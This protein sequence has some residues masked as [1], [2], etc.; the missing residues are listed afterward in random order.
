MRF[1][2]AMLCILFAFLLLQF[3]AS[4]GSVYASV[5]HVLRS[6]KI[7]AIFPLS[8]FLWFKY[9]STLSKIEL[10]IFLHGIL[11]I[12]IPLSLFYIMSAN[13]LA[14]YRA[15]DTSHVFF[16][17][18]T[19]YGTAVRDL[20]TI[21]AFLFVSLSYALALFAL[22]FK[23]HYALI[24]FLLIIA[25]LSTATRGIA[26]A[27]ILSLAVTMLHIIC[28]HNTSN[29]LTQI[30][31]IC[32]IV[33]S[34]MLL[35]ARLPILHHLQSRIEDV[36][37]HGT[38]TS[39]FQHRSESIN[40]V[41]SLISN[42]TYTFLFGNGYITSSY[43]SANIY[44]YFADSMYSRLLYMFGTLGLLLY[45]VVLSFPIY[46]AIRYLF[47]LTSVPLLTSTL[48]SV[49]FLSMAY[50]G[51]NGVNSDAPIYALPYGLFLAG[52]FLSNLKLSN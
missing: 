31:Y 10:H 9:F 45:I 17:T 25:A 51:S 14:L 27:L 11:Y 12:T 38:S 26:V 36:S 16:Q 50:I 42:D 41:M 19:M 15:P 4:T 18:S 37:E 39:N 40:Y 2:I 7:Y 47:R 6:S 33:L 5:L 8:I 44:L 34:F 30:F 20:S 43:Y 46:Y 21:P 32:I 3:A 23:A 28:K 22:R 48:H 24:A 29:R 35:W 13:G 49:L 52:M 1:Y